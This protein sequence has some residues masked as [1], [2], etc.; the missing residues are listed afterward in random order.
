[1]Q[2]QAPVGR[3]LFRNLSFR[4]PALMLGRFFSVI[5]L[6]CGFMALAWGFVGL[7]AELVRIDLAASCTGIVNPDRK[8]TRLNSSHT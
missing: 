1:M 5:W 7:Y 8:S 2:T 3:N 6:L 4:K